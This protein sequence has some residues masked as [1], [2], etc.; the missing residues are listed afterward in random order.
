M[1][2]SLGTYIF[3]CT[4]TR[5]NAPTVQEFKGFF[6]VNRHA[7][8]K[9]KINLHAKSKA[10]VNLCAK[11][12]RICSMW[13]FLENLYLIPTVTKAVRIK[14]TS[15]QVKSPPKLRMTYCRKINPPHNCNYLLFLKVCKPAASHFVRF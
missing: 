14:S 8:S 3:I 10:K 6:K 15:K 9:T 4:G 13:R 5:T 12:K 1:N 7:K 2:K 11:S